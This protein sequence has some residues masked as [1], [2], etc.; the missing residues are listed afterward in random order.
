MSTIKNHVFEINPMRV[1]YPLYSPNRTK[2]GKSYFLNNFFH[3]W[4]PLPLL[5]DDGL[6]VMTVLQYTA[7]ATGTKI[8]LEGSEKNSPGDFHGLSAQGVMGQAAVGQVHPKNT[9]VG[10][11]SPNA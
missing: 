6:T 2:L 1:T 3:I 9:V 7:P 11:A 8:G 10:Q 4:A 5:S